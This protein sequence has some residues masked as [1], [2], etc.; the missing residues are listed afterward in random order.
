MVIS[1]FCLKYGPYTSVLI[2]PNTPIP[3]HSNTPTL[4]LYFNAQASYI[5]LASR[6]KFSIL[7]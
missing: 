5:D 7:D 3:Q 2:T 1:L 4:R 6:T